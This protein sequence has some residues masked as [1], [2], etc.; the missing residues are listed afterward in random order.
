MKK[1]HLFLFA[2]AALFAVESSA[3]NF[4]IDGRASVPVEIAF[5]SKGCNPFRMGKDPRSFTVTAYRN[6]GKTYQKFEFT[7]MPKADGVLKLE[8]K[9][10]YSRTKGMKNLNQVWITFDDIKA[11]GTQIKNGSFETLRTTPPGQ[12]VE[13]WVFAATKPVYEARLLKADGNA[14]DGKNAVCVWHNAFCFQE[15]IP[16]KQGVKVTISFQAKYADTEK[17]EE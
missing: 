15:N 14:A 2:A 9:G 7:I 10:Q 12:P 11:T 16:L 17:A 1:L 6:L 5:P 13:S 4:Q 3:G 8:F